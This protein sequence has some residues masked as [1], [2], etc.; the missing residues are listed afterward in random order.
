MHKYYFLLVLLFLASCSPSPKQASKYNNM[1]IRQQRKV[2]EK[3]DD[4]I[5]SFS[6][7]NKKQ[8]DQAYQ[9]LLKTIDQAIDTV[10]NMGGFDGST[11]FRDKTLELLKLY[12]DV[13]ENEF[14]TVLNLLSKKDYSNNDAKIV[15]ETMLQARNRLSRANKD[16]EQYQQQFAKKYNLKLV[17]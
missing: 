7:Y 15:S 13:T 3:M 5:N 6:L 1:L 9:D 8:M 4:L 12:K 10:S 16:F 2:I 14:H 17:E 11:E